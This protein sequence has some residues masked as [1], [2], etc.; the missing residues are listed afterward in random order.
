ML[1][2]LH[3]DVTA[4]T[5][6]ERAKNNT[7]F[8]KTGPGQYGEGDQ[9]A[10]LTL[11]QV[12]GLVRKYRDLS[13]EDAE[14]LLHSP[15]HEERLLALLIL[16]QRCR[17]KRTDDA[18]R[19]RIYRLYLDNT[20]YVNNWDL[21]DCSAAYIVGPYLQDKPKDVLFK[22]AASDLVWDRRI[23]VIATFHYIK[24]GDCTVAL[25]VAGALMTDKH[26]LIHKATGWMLRE[27]EKRCG[28]STLTAFLDQHAATM[29]RTALRYALERFDPA[30]RAHYMSLKSQ[31]R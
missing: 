28:H 13:P 22:L 31:R 9:F 7:W 19:E 18:T 11:T 2:A 5:S 25:Q 21:V 17:A 30:E 29:P 14:A 3:A 20:A 16:V 8:F 1:P 23:A 24:G 15:L 10:G 26:D 12:R 27:V 6:P 4:L